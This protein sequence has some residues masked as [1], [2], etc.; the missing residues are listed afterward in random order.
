MLNCIYSTP[1][2]ML[3]TVLFA[4]CFSYKTSL[5]ALVA[6]DC[7]SVLIQQFFCQVIQAQYVSII[8]HFKDP[9][10]V[11]PK[12]LFVLSRFHYNWKSIRYTSIAVLMSADIS[13][14]F[15]HSLAW[16]GWS[17]IASYVLYDCFNSH[18]IHYNLK[19][20]KKRRIPLKVRAISGK[21]IY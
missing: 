4:A 12:R 9:P 8:Y 18:I 13:K 14:R 15:I 19:I 20:V 7:L 21:I 6:T 3:N 1:R 16:S 2:R 17:L 5:I 10:V 11:F